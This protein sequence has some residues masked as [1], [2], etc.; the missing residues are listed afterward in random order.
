MPVFTAIAA[1]ATALAGAIG[2]SAAAAG[3]AGSVAAFAARTLLTVGLTK[4]MVN[5]AGQSGAGTS[6]AGSRVQL[7]PATDN[8][9]SVIYGNAFI[10]GSITDAKISTD[11]KTM[12][13][14]V[15]LADV[16]D[17][18]PGS[19]YTFGNIYYDNKLVTFG[20]GGDAAKVVSLTTNTIG[21]PEVD[22]KID[23]N[24][25]IYLFTNGS[26]SGVNTGGQ[27]AINIMSDAAIPSDQRW[28]QGIY[29]ASGQSATM[30]NTAFAIVKVIY[31]QDAGT[32]NLGSLTVQLQNSLYQ[33]GAVIKDYLSNARYGCAVPASKINSASLAALDAYSAQTI[34]YVPVGGGTATQARYRIDGPLNTGQNCLNNLQQLVDSCDSW[35]Q[36]SEMSGE[37]KVVINQ[38]YT[39]YTTLGQLYEVDSS[40]L[41]GGVEVNPLDLNGTFNIVEVQYPN[42]NIKDQTD[43]QTISLFTSYPS[44][45]SPNEPVNK[46]NV[47]F[48]Q[49]NNAVQAKYLALRRLFQAR[50]DL[51]VSFATD[52]SGIQVEAGD[53]IKITL[54]QYGWTDKLFR[55]TFV[56]EQKYPDGSLGATMTAFE[57]N[58][59]VYDDNLV[60][61]FIPASNTGLSDPNII[62]TPAAPTVTNSP[63]N[64]G[65][66][67]SQFITGIVPT[68]G[69][70]LYMDFNYGTTSDV[71]THIRYTT[72]TLGGGQLYTA[73]T[74][75]QVEMSD[76][77]EGT[78]YWSVTARNNSAGVSSPATLGPIWY[79]ASVKPSDNPTKTNVSSVGTTLTLPT[80]TDGIVPG[81]ILTRTGGTGT[82][83]AGTSVVSVVDGTTIT[84]S[85]APSPALSGSTVVFKVTKT[86]C[87]S[88]GTQITVPNTSGIS[89]G[90][91]PTVSGGTGSFV[92]GTVIVSIDSPIFI[93]VSIA[94]TVPLS[95]ATVDFTGGGLDGGSYLQSGS[96]T[97]NQMGAGAA[98]FCNRESYDP[99]TVSG[100]SGIALATATSTINEP[101]VYPGY[102][103]PSNYVN[104]WYSGTWS[105]SW[106]T[107]PTGLGYYEPAVP[108]N[109]AQAVSGTRADFEALGWLL[110]IKV[111]FNGDLLTP[112]EWAVL[113]GYLKVQ[114]DVAGS[115][116]QICRYAEFSPNA[117]TFQLRTLEQHVIGYD[118][119]YVQNVPLAD[120]STG[121]SASIYSYGYFIRNL[122][123]GSGLTVVAAS[124]SV[125]QS[126]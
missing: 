78:Y 65:T 29:T 81:Q 68:P 88:S 51:V 37:W 33:P 86:G 82:I 94:P 1:G 99:R 102:A 13:Y 84:V 55:V 76:L 119:T 58:D 6:N 40:N 77:P 105:Y 4:L 74:S 115:S 126:K 5:K 38:S 18:T 54:E 104:T 61:D 11:Q 46:L 103:V 57:Y 120:G 39:D 116:F 125:K 97:I 64:D 36:Y 47:Q 101:A 34:T 48:P 98:G 110:A 2:F 67:S 95:G 43:F 72:T 100:G 111:D 70:V 112:S 21:T 9:L 45:L 23:G 122:T 30:T 16:T 79:G 96:I 89:V 69:A 50:E 114:T 15:S 87:A 10:G 91:S 28:D 118:G 49:V 42:Y 20:T 106:T 121:S 35:L 63:L 75:I 113:T 19:A 22:T 59:T 124:L 123:F 93:T 62:G 3:I 14:V 66:N 32:T 108:G 44:L 53:V 109:S 92:L 60:Q 73:G 26:S 17:S 117:Y 56:G 41:I 24:L 71:K 31:N 8:K 27:T 7:P 80:G 90:Q 52:Y 12:W 83:G 107:A 85:S 25:F